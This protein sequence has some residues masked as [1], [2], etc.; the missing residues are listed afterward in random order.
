MEIEIL[1]GES[2]VA[3]KLIIY[4]IARLSI[5]RTADMSVQS[6]WLSPLALVITEPETNASSIVSL[7]SEKIDN[8]ELTKMT[9]C[10]IRKNMVD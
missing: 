6:F 8:V 9:L 3:G 10:R 5:L 7:T 1:V 4:P 2:M